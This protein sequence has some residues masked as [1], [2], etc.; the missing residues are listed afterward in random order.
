M[1]LF[2]GHMNFFRNSVIVFGVSLN[3]FCSSCCQKKSVP[4]G[5]VLFDGP[6]TIKAEFAVLN[7]SDWLNTPLRGNKI[8]VNVQ[9][10]SKKD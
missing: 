10:H 7:I 6:G 1:L 4:L 2:E 8:C 5:F 3:F 9:S